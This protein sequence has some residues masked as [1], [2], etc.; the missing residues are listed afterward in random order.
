MTT[1]PY[2]RSSLA[3]SLYTKMIKDDNLR[4]LDKSKWYEVSLERVDCELHESFLQS[5][6]DGE[7][8]DFLEQCFDKSDWLFT[9]L[10]QA[11]A[12]SLMSWFMSRTSI[13]G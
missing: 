12:R 7:T 5:C 13:N 10:F 11:L 1:T 4:T 9:Q 2:L 3:R 8:E 6:V